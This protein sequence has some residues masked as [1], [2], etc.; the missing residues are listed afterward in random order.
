MTMDSALQSQ[1][2]RLWRLGVYL[3]PYEGERSVFE[4]SSDGKLT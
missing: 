4:N 3:E 1:K 2:H